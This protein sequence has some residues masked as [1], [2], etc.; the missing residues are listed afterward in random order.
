MLMTVQAA[1]VP[2]R[3]GGGRSTPAKRQ[4]PCLSPGTSSQMR[5]RTSPWYGSRRPCSSR[6][7]GRLAGSRL[8]L[9]PPRPLLPHNSLQSSCSTLQVGRGWTGSVNSYWFFSG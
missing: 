5:S 3:H 8:S 1:A 2:R 4:R 9:H 6:G 7:G